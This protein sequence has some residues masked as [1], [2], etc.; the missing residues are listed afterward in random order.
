[1][2]GL[3]I[4]ILIAVAFFEPYNLAQTRSVMTLYGMLFTLSL[5]GA[6]HDVA[7]DGPSNPF[8]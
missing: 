3:S 5:I 2:Q 4:V 7:T 8:A 6:T 1:M